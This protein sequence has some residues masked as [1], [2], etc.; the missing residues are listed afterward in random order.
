MADQQLQQCVAKVGAPQIAKLMLAGVR[1]GGS[2]YLPTPFRWGYG[3]SYPRGY[4]V[5]TTEE[6]NQINA[7][8][9]STDNI[10]NSR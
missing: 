8:E 7:L 1:V 10:V 6:I 5:L 9:N 2:P 3:W 4:K